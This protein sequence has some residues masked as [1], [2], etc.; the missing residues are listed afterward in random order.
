MDCINNTKDVLQ[1]C[2]GNNVKQVF[3]KY[4]CGFFFGLLVL[5][6]LLKW[7]LEFFSAVVVPFCAVW[8]GAWIALRSSKKERKRVGLE[9]TLTE[10]YNPLLFTFYTKDE[11]EN[12]QNKFSRE[13]IEKSGFE[14]NGS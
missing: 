6:A 5:L 3:Q 13:K 4:E 8:F 12:P 11:W 9:S 14:K 10:F 7:N 2:F 1:E